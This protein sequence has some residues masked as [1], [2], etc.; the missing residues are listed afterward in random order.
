MHTI[1]SREGLQ[2]QC[3]TNR[4]LHRV[5]DRWTEHALEGVGRLGHA[6][7]GWSYLRLQGPIQRWRKEEKQLLEK[8]VASAVSSRALN[9]TNVLIIPS[10]HKHT[11]TNNSFLQNSMIRGHHSS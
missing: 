6:E 5:V 10:P 3:P 1:R 11:H 4:T 8:R 2:T 7:P 9:N